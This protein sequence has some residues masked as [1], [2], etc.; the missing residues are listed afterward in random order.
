LRIVRKR[1]V[2]WDYATKRRLKYA[3]LYGGYLKRY[4]QA[5]P[6][7]PTIVVFAEKQIAGWALALENNHNNTVGINL[8][9]NKRYRKRGIATILAEEALKDFRV[10]SLAEHDS[11][12]R[13]FFKKLKQKHSEKIII[14]DWWKHRHKYDKLIQAALSS[15]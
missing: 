2:D 10:I 4:I 3:T 11:T 7:S 1:F 14:F 13:S 15:K 9:V 6:Q 8:F 12:T 5:F